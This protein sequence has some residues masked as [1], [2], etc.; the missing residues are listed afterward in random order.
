MSLM[1][2]PFSIRLFVAAGRPAEDQFAVLADGWFNGNPAGEYVGD[3]FREQLQKGG[4]QAQVSA[5]EAHWQLG[6]VE[7]HGRILKS[8]LSRIDHEQP[9]T[10]V[11]EFRRCLRAAIQAKNNLSR[12]NEFAPEQAVLGKMARLPG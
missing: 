6:R 5:G 7:A 10:E 9:I 1:R 4:M 2:Q 8:M 3:H 11:G 12:V